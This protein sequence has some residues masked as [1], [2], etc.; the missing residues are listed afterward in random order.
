VDL[1]TG[2]DIA[3]V[4]LI[5]EAFVLG[6]VP[7]AIFFYAI[8]GM[9]ALRSKLDPLI[10]M[11]Q[12][13]LARVAHTTQNVSDSL[14]RPVISLSSRWRQAQSTVQAMWR[15]ETPVPV[16]WDTGADPLSPEREAM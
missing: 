15:R 3:L 12:D 14:V 7:A 2:R 11:A 5:V 10:P 8:R 9:T 1:S 16:R 6:L 4:V 13:R